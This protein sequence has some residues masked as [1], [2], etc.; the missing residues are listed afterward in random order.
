MNSQ[1]VF[2]Q[3]VSIPHREFW[4]ISGYKKSG[5]SG[6]LVVWFVSSM[7]VWRW[8]DPHRVV[9]VIVGKKLKK[10]FSPH[11]SVGGS[12]GNIL[13]CPVRRSLSISFTPQIDHYLWP[14]TLNLW[15]P[16]HPEAW[17]KHQ[18]AVW[19]QTCLWATV[20]VRVCISV[21]SVH[22]KWFIILVNTQA[23]MHTHALTPMYCGG[24]WTACQ[25]DRVTWMS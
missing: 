5:D 15:S 20:C 24:T 11:C 17:D 4:T 3:S 8:K 14:I 10:T 23:H 2:W 21:Y 9:R 12:W 16:V 25:V 22:W 6:W 7:C 19:I 1:A 13:V 18:H